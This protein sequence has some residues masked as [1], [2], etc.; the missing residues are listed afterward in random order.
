[1]ANPL[2]TLQGLDKPQGVQSFM[3]GVSQGAEAARIPMQ[4]RLLEAQ[5]KGAEQ[6]LTRQQAEF[7]LQDMATDALQIKELAQ[8]DP[9][10]AQVALA[11]RIK[12]ITDRGGDPS[13]TMAVRELLTAGRMDEFNA[14]LDAPINA[15]RQRGLIGVNKTRSLASA[16]RAELLKAIQPALDENG[17]FN[18]EKADAAAMSAARELNIIAKPGTLTSPERIPLTGM[19]GTVAG[20]QEK[21]KRGEA[22]GASTGKASSEIESLADQWDANREFIVSAVPGIQD[23]LEQTPGSS[24]GKA[25]ASFL[26]KSIGSMETIDAQAELEQF[27]AILLQGVPFAPGAQ[28]DKELQARAKLVSDQVED[29]NI[30]PS[31]KV[32]IIKRFIDYQDAKSSAQ[33]RIA[34]RKMGNES[35][36]SQSGQKKQGGQMMIDANG[37]KAMV[38]PDGTFEEVK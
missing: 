28:S 30:S 34:E 9:M 17:N 21:I 27:A 13:D 7:Q 16:D 12:K 37:N 33:R 24:L 18:P 5:T 10:R 23:I 19:T 32:D 4:N 35:K 15:A 11:E 8:V 36:P 29:P 14:E 20:S 6:Q 3:A 2:I 25:T 26:S 1:M 22:Y 31:K 38:Y